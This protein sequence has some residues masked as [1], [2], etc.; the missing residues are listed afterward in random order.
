[1]FGR[2][3]SSFLKEKDAMRMTNLEILG[4]LGSAVGYGAQGIQ[5]GSGRQE[6]WGCRG[7]S[8]LGDLIGGYV[9]SWQREIAYLCH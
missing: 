9:I 8:N 4:V 6:E 2:Q 5:S 1:M 7:G 3:V